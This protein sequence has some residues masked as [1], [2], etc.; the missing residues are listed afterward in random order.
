MKTFKYLNILFIASLVG[1]TNSID[2]TSTS[3]LDAASYYSNLTE[4]NTALIGCYKGL[5]KPILDEWNLTETRSDNTWMANTGSTSSINL[6]LASQDMFFPITSNQNIYNYW[7]NTYN[8]IYNV[9]MLM[10]GLGASYNETSGILEYKDFTLPV[11]DVDRKRIAAEASFIRA[12]HYFNMVRLFGDTFLVHNALTPDEAKK[13]NRVPKAEIYKLIIAD[14]LNAS[15]N[16]S[17]ARYNAAANDL[18]RSNSWAAKALLAKVYLTLGRKADASLL[19]TDVINNSGYSLQASYANV[20]STTNEM[21]SEIL[22]SV[23]FKGGGFDMGSPL[24]NSFAPTKSG[25]SII[26]GDG[27][28]YNTPSLDIFTSYSTTAGN[29]DLRRDVNVGVFGTSTYLKYYVK[30]FICVVAVK[31]DADSDWPVL[32]FSD[33]LLMQ[34]EADGNTVGSLAQINKVHT[35]A[36]LIPLVT[37]DVSTTAKFETLLSKERKL[38]FAFE[39]QRWF[40]LMRQNTTFETPALTV[41]AVMDAHVK[42]VAS[43]TFYSKFKGGLTTA[44][45]SANIKNRILLPIPQREIDNNSNLVIPQNPNY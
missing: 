44:Q 7:F 32:R 15:A 42:S 35:R 8:N 1:C 3:N 45:I 34:A 22:F 39:N 20:F 18:G 6:D 36:G 4:L 17:T 33:V 29:I 27:G 40:D 12:H 38:E 43:T 10:K 25:S 30:K 31:N 23:R 5:Q 13:M 28:G 2:L 21:N 14:L 41:E 19:L 37:A 9:N 11:A 16:G 24:P 26:N